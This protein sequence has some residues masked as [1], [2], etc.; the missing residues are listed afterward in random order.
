MKR[1]RIIRVMGLL[2]ALMMI[3][4]CTGGKAAEGFAETKELAADSIAIDQIFRPRQHVVAGDK[5]VF[6]GMEADTLGYVFR[7]PDFEFLYGGIRT[8]GGPEEMSNVYV[9]LVAEYSDSGRFIVRDYGKG[10]R[11]FKAGER[12]F[13]PGGWVVAD[14]KDS[15]GESGGA[16]GVD[17]L[18]AETYF[19][20]PAER[21]MLRLFDASRGIYTDTTETSTVFVTWQTGDYTVY[22]TANYGSSVKMGGALAVVYNETGRLDIYD[23]SSG[24]FVLKNTVGDATSLEEL[25]KVDFEGRVS[26]TEYDGLCTDGRYLYV[27]ANDYR[28]DDR[29]EGRKTVGSFVL[30][31][32]WLGNP[33]RK[34]RLEKV[35]DRILAFDGKVYAFDTMFDLDKMYVYD[36]GV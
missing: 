2:L 11:F 27:L 33:V 12:A 16:V 28:M 4:A 23:I 30:V 24:K 36:P 35:A 5:A 9:D 18:I 3:S 14:R 17:S 6:F 34:C 15:A 13:E 22:T 7:L 1:V 19:D 21:V 8:G 32:D 29:E 26:G 25:K 31:Y 20:K 10:F